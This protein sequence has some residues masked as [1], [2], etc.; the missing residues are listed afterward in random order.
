MTKIISGHRLF[1]PY[2]GLALP[3]YQELFES[4]ND[5]N[6]SQQ[7]HRLNVLI[8]L[9]LSLKEVGVCKYNFNCSPI[10]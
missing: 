1:Y 4:Q 8:D 3:G 10:E 2:L 9:M 7:P 6:W 5:G